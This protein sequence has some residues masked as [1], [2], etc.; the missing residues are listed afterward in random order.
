[1]AR[2]VVFA[3]GVVAVGAAIVLAYGHAL[4]NALAAGP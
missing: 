4:L 1:M 3:L 2:L